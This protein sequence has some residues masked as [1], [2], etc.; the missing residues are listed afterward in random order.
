MRYFGSILLLSLVM[1]FT[2]AGN[3]KQNKFLIGTWHVERID[4]SSLLEGVSE[5]E[6]MLI[7][8][9]IPMLEESMKS[10]IWEFKSNGAFNSESSIM[11]EEM[12]TSGSWYLNDDGKILTTEVNGEKSEYVLV[13]LTK[14]KLTTALIVDDQKIV[15]EM[16]KK[17]K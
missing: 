5:D 15:I 7:E 4:F 3:K 9:V 10:L 17:K 8:L 13:L 11:G 2:S 6:K 14:S 12:N 1:S 16:I